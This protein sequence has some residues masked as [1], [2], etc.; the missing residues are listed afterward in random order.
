[1]ISIADFCKRHGACMD[2]QRWA[3]KNCS[4]MDEAWRAAPNPNWVVWIATR[5]GVLSERDQRLFGCWA[6]RQVWHLLT[7]ER[8]RRA[9]EVAEKY[10][11]GKA[12]TDDLADAWLTARYATRTAAYGSTREAAEGAAWVTTLDASGASFM[13]AISAAEAVDWDDARAAQAEY[14]RKHFSPFAGQV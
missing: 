9:V 13:A 4:S 6:V 2:G 1:M 5:E 3:M 10:A 14:L 7:D 12:T 8:S 11:V